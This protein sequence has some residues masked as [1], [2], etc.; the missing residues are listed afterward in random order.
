MAVTDK[1]SGLD[2]KGPIL[3]VC[4]QLISV[5]SA[6]CLEKISVFLN[7]EIRHQKKVIWTL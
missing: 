5:E 1:L 3:Q 2:F 6:C 7:F 4:I